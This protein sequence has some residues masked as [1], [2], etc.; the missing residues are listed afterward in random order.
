MVLRLRRLH[1]VRQFPRTS[2]RGHFE[3]VESSGACIS[4]SEPRRGRCLGFSGAAVEAVLIE[5]LV[6][7][8]ALLVLVEHLVLGFHLTGARD[9]LLQFAHIRVL[10]SA[11]DGGCFFLLTTRNISMSSFF[12]CC[13]VGAGT[14]SSARI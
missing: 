12:S 5:R 11:Q 7:V 13:P 8:Y 6:V 2:Q 1:H 10:V 3:G 4:E 9:H 14:R